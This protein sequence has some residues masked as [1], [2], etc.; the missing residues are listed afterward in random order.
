MKIFKQKQSVIKHV[1][2]FILALAIVFSSCSDFL[3]IVPDNVATLDHAFSNTVETEKYLFTCYSYIPNNADIANNPAMLSGDEFWI[4]EMRSTNTWNIIAKGLQNT[5][6]PAA[7]CWDGFDNGIESFKA[8]RHCNTFIEN[9][10]DLSKIRDLP[11]DKR[12]RWL[13]EAKFLKAF[14]HFHLLRHYGPIPI[15]DKN[16]PISAKPEELK[17]KRKPVDECVEYITSLLDECYDD[18]PT[19]ILRETDELGRITKS[20]N[21]AIKAR[22]LLLSASPLFNGNPDYKNFLDKDGV[23][24]FNPVEDIN[25][26]KMAADA[27]KEAIDVAEQAGNKLYYYTNP[28]F[29]MTDT[30]LIQMSIRGA[31]TERWNDEVIWGLSDRRANG[32][33]KSSQ[34]YLDKEWNYDDAQGL[35]AP[36]LKIIE[37]FYTFNGVPIEED[38]LLDFNNYNKLRTATRAERVNFEERYETARINFDRENRFYASVGFD[39]GKWLTADLPAQ[40]DYEA[41]TVKGKKG[42]ISSGEIMGLNSQTGYYTKKTV[43][44]ES[45]FRSNST[46]MREYPWP[47]IRLAD[48]YL[49]YAEALNE[50]EGPVADVHKYL[51]LIR[52]RAGLNG[53]EESWTKFSTNPAK[54]NTK[55]G[56]REIIHRERLIELSFEGS[57]FW[58]LRRWKKAAE[59]LNAPITGW[60]VTQ[61]E[62]HA[63]YQV[64]SYFQQKFI[65]PRDYLWPLRDDELS[66]N[67]N[68]VQNPGW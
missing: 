50:V 64:V 23:M 62:S 29:S 18:L 19:T 42:Q 65:S 5:A 43:N 25:K 26:W 37:Q 60:D 20:I 47:E 32:I 34:A 40:I 53:V 35:L 51:N 2:L 67:L 30:T 9:V 49:M 12:I 16:L 63:Y 68:L 21:R 13:A 4:N 11:L 57:R 14:Y 8:I 36:P 31:V 45:V 48:V 15:V 3:D 55:E 10:G 17:V 6:N 66:V 46:G 38:K 22:V 52:E 61:K 58:D 59:V 54:P 33:Q 56:M 44:W 24:L 41:L 39:G 28:K 7:N 27:A 1:Y